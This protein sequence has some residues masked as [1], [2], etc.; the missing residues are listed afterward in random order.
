[1]LQHTLSSSSHVQ[2]LSDSKTSHA[3]FMST[4]ALHMTRL[5]LCSN[6]L[7]T[8]T[9]TDVIPIAWHTGEKKRENAE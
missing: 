4:P 1:M 8:V 9:L 6:G 3:S 7:T 2:L 5:T